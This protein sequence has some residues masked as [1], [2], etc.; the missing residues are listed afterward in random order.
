MPKHPSVQTTAA[1]LI[2]ESP[3]YDKLRDAAAGCRACPLW[4][5]G[6]QTVFGEPVGRPH[7]GPR[8][9]LVG[10]QP[11]DQE[12][13]E[14][15]PFVGPSG[16]LLDE[17]LD[18][19]SIDRSQVYV[20]NTVK[21]FKWK[22]E[23]GHR[24]V[25]AKPSTTEIRACLPWLAAEIRVFRPDILVCLGATAAQALLGKDFRVTKQRGEPVDSD[26]ARIVVATVHPS[27]ILRAPDPE[28]RERQLD[29]FIDD[30]RVVARLIHGL[31]A[32]EGA[33]ALH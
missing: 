6:T 31:G 3:T 7:R 14:G 32:E 1:P 5:T 11:G 9:M 2:P 19:A 33:H 10:E 18:A 27:S 4:K 26:W 15:R 22:G 28:A 12:D 24:R 25:H 30:L 20:T 13:R 8:V 23:E 16:R 21:H 17:A 29:A